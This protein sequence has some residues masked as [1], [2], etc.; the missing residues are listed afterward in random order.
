MTD[1]TRRGVNAVI[2]E[3]ATSLIELVGHRKTSAA[4]EVLKNA[5]SSVVASL[6][7]PRQISTGTAAHDVGRPVVLTETTGGCLFRK[8]GMA[9]EV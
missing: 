7:G 1:R 2:V 6:S 8:Q 3:A 9:S 5:A 4:E